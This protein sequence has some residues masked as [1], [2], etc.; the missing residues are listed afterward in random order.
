MLVKG[1]KV[2][3]TRPLTAK[4]DTC[5]GKRI[6][7]QYRVTDVIDDSLRTMYTSHGQFATIGNSRHKNP[8]DASVHV[9]T[10]YLFTSALLL[11]FALA[12]DGFEDPFFAA[13][14]VPERYSYTMQTTVSTTAGAQLLYINHIACTTSCTTY[15]V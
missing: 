1:V 3:A 15:T 6:C 13:T 12:P 14:A 10:E 7:Y 9:F 8:W 2:A 5:I 4:R 11:G